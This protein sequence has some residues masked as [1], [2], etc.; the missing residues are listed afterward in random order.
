MTRNSTFSIHHFSDNKHW[1]TRHKGLFLLREL[2][3]N[4]LN[5]A[6]WKL[7]THDSDS[8]L[9]WPQPSVPVMSA[10][11]RLLRAWSDGGCDWCR[12]YGSK[13]NPWMLCVQNVW[14]IVLFEKKKNMLKI[15]KHWQE[16]Q[17]YCTL[18]T[19]AIGWLSLVSQRRVFCV[20]DAQFMVTVERMNLSDVERYCVVSLWYK[21]MNKWQAFLEKQQKQPSLQQSIQPSPFRVSSLR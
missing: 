8:W 21:T 3:L 19:S 14:S 4:W 17:K 15:Q 10:C 2:V 18:C 20:W 6:K 1:I 9:V 7:M 11:R 16:L 12:G 5:L 13:I